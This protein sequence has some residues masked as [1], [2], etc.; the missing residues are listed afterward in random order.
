MMIWLLLGILLVLVVLIFFAIRRAN[1]LGKTTSIYYEPTIKPQLDELYD[2]KLAE[3]PVAY[4]TCYIDT[5]YGEVFVIIS[6]QKEAQPILLLH[7]ASVTSMS[8]INNVAALAKNYRVYAID[9]IGEPGK[10][11]LSDVNHY[12]KSGRDLA[13]LY[14][15]ITQKLGIENAYVV[16]ASYGGFI[17]AN[18]AIYAPERVKKLA[19]LGSMGVTPNTGWVAIKLTL[20]TFYP[21]EPFKA[22]MVTWSLGD[23]SSLDWCLK[24]FRLVLDGVQ[25]RFFPPA[26]FKPDE[27]QRINAPILLVLGTKDNLVGDPGKVRQYAQGIPNLRVE[28]LDTGHLIGVEQPERVNELILDFFSKT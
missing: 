22:H 1:F 13:D 26:T 3:W 17:A 11:Q 15:D 10:S 21:V 8:W 2:E 5:V 6:G 14:T 7:A 25:G 9:T 27:L 16:G 19:L 12:P 24:Y 4:E 20:F 23:N 18:Y 28:V